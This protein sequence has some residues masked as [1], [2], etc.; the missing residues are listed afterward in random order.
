MAL[1]ELI[2]NS[3]NPGVREPLTTLAEALSEAGL[4]LKLTAKLPTALQGPGQTRLLIDNEIIL[5]EATSETTVTIL[6]RGAEGSTKK[7]HVS[8]SQV[9]HILT[10]EGAKRALTLGASTA[11][12]AYR[13]SLQKIPTASGTRVKL[14]KVLFDLGANFNIAEGF[15]VVPVAGYYSVTGVASIALTAVAEATF[16]V[17]IGVNGIERIRGHRFEAKPG[18]PGLENGT[19]AGIL[20][21]AKGDKVELI[22]WQ[23]TG[24]ERELEIAETENR[25]DVVRMA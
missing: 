24:A 22:A 19:A 18:A 23:F 7:A 16:I 11:G 10:T 12:S 8:G 14:D 13:S 9:Y 6:E 25:L 1:P 4:S 20:Q 15:Y 5:I 17:A 2:A 21:L 3:P